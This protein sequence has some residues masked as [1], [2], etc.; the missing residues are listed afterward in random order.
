MVLECFNIT[1]DNGEKLES[2]FTREESEKMELLISNF[3]DTEKLSLIISNLSNRKKSDIKYLDLSETE[4]RDFTELKKLKNLKILE[5]KNSKITD[6]RSSGLDT[7]VGL[8]KL[9]I[10]DSELITD[11]EGLSSLENLTEL[12]LDNTSFNDINI[13][14]NCSKLGVLSLLN[15]PFKI[16]LNEECEGIKSLLNFSD[17]YKLNVDKS[18]FVLFDSHG[19]HDELKNFSGLL[20]QIFNSIIKLRKRLDVQRVWEMHVLPLVLQKYCMFSLIHSEKCYAE[21]FKNF[22]QNS[23]KPGFDIKCVVKLVNKELEHCRETINF[24]ETINKWKYPLPEDLTG[25]IS[26]YLLPVRTQFF[27]VGETRK[28]KISCDETIFNFHQNKRK[29]I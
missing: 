4:I 9:D 26:E 20:F 3:D 29:N 17:L 10:S 22:I 11:F 15:T 18:Q 12:V 16:E 19:N 25:E 1:D 6:I 5:I 23:Y 28:R 27:I 14:K 8:N 7:L 2:I 21:D 13:L 24:K